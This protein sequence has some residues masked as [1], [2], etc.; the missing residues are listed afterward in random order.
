MLPLNYGCRT[1]LKKIKIKS[2]Q[3][4]T[5]TSANYRYQNR[6]WQKNTGIKGLRKINI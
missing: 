2:Y 6:F 4:D 5:I 1:N 3:S